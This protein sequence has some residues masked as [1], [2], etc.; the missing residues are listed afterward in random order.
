MLSLYDRIKSKKDNPEQNDQR[1]LEIVNLIQSIRADL[2][3]EAQ[4]Q[5]IDG[6]TKENLE[7]NV[8]QLLENYLRK[9]ERFLPKEEKQ[10]LIEQIVQDISG[11]GPLQPL[12]D[13]EDISE[14]MINGPK[15]VFIE[16]KGKLTLSSTKFINDSHVMNVIDK[17]IAPLGRRLDESSPK[18][19]ARLPDGSRINAIIPPL[20]LNGPTVTIRKFQ[21][22][23][24]TINHLIQYKSLN[25]EMAN[26]LHTAVRGRMNVLVAGGTGS[27]K[28]T[29]LNILSSFI[30]KDERIV[31][32]E[33]AAE[34]TLNQPH[35]VS[36]ETRPPNIEGKGEITIR[37]L[38]INS[39]RMRPDRIIVGEVRG[40]EAL[41]MLQ[42]MNTG[43]DGSLSTIHANTPRDVISRLET[44]ILMSGYDLPMKAIRQQIASAV[45][46]IVLQKRFSDG[47]RKITHVTLVEGMENE[48]ITL[49]D[50]F[51]FEE[52]TTYKNS[53]VSGRYVKVGAP[54]KINGHGWE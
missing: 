54:P 16:K 21:K 48:T 15:Q 31:T 20:A 7:K 26:F 2:L 1:E 49:Q 43:H 11:L 14:I 18:V 30:P 10:G 37:D 25:R 33:D 9:S 6:Q 28:T 36:L 12:L 53:K 13:N 45:D 29:L 34:L 23:R 42:A 32:I 22:D 35:V 24:L 50:L 5:N 39:L 51:V 52:V 41:D 46:L 3:F 4:T 17:I 8:K 44:L 19:D 47:S 40:G 38:V 27:G